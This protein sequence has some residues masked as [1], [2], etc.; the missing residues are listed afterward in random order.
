MFRYV[1]IDDYPFPMYSVMALFG[2]VFVI[3]IGLAKHKALGLRKRDVLILVVYATIGA[4]AGAKL[5]SVIGQIVKHGG[6]PGF[7]TA[8]HWLHILGAGGVFYGGLLGALG[9][10]ALRAK[11]GRIELTSMFNYAAY[12]ALAFQ[13][14]GRIGCYCAGCCYGV[15]LFK[16]RLA[17]RRALWYNTPAGPK[18]APCYAAR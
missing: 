13:S 4:I 7:W 12:A 3:V 5:F 11:T 16:K 9:M 17:F 8:E 14:L 2:A 1:Y 15:E 18:A 6:E 10:A